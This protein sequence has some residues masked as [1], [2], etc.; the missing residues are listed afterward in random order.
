MAVKGADTDGVR[1]ALAKAVAHRDVDART[2]GSIAK[3][4]NY[5]HRIRGIDPCIYGICLDFVVDR[6]DLDDIIR[7][8]VDAGRIG[9]IRVFPWGIPWP[10]VF[11]V[12]IEQDIAGIPQG[13]G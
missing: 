5:G 6:L 2:I 11:H 12:R 3:K 7:G 9:E 4:L 10:D 1:L 8:A 13:V